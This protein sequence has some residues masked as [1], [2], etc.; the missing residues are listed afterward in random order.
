MSSPEANLAALGLI[1]PP[2]PQL[3]PGITLPFALVRVVGTRALI[4]GH[5][6]TLA[7][8]RLAGPFGKVGAEVSEAEAVAAARLTTLAMLGSLKRQLGSLERIRAWTKVLGLVASAPHFHRQPVVMNGCSELL[9]QI[10]GPEV[11]AH[12]RSAIGVAVLPFDLPVE[13]EAEVELHA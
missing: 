9:L 12:A 11:G 8:G 3:P 6:P 4:A 2:A 7:D 10:F 13:I 1:L 5:G